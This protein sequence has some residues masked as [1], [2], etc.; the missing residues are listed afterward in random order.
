MD[1]SWYFLGF[2][3][4]HLSPANS[5]PLSNIRLKC[6]G[7]RYVTN[8]VCNFIFIFVCIRYLYWNLSFKLSF[9]QDETVNN[10]KISRSIDYE[11]GTLVSNTKSSPTQQPAVRRKTY[12][13]NFPFDENSFGE[14]N[15]LK[16]FDG[17][18]LVKEYQNSLDTP[19]KIENISAQDL[20]GSNAGVEDDANDYID[21]YLR[22]ITK[23]R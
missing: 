19:S 22:K 18:E 3:I 4:C 13:G 20:N 8:V 14:N 16:H 23:T 17:I 12:A 11:T 1:L 7:Y 10:R 21:V 2:D 15:N 6:G 5:K 9:S